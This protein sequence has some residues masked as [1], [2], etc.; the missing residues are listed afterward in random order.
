MLVA[1]DDD[2]V[3]AVVCRLLDD[4]GY[5]VLSAEDGAAALEPTFV[6]IGEKLLSSNAKPIAELVASAIAK[7]EA[8]DTVMDAIPLIGTFKLVRQRVDQSRRGALR[9]SAGHQSTIVVRQLIAADVSVPR[10]TPHDVTGS[11]EFATLRYKRWYSNDTGANPDEDPWIV[12]ITGD[13]GDTWVELENTIVSD[14]SWALQ[15]FDLLAIFP[16]SGE[17]QV[18]FEASDYDGNTTIEEV[19][20]YT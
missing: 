19:L 12:Q 8:L 17:F 14:R 20:K 3:R 16:E 1:E 10:Q 4:N 9:P 5:R 13:G 6:S 11:T 18:M 2:T 15:E 7:G